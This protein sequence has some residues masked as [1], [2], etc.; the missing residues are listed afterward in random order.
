MGAIFSQFQPGDIVSGR[1]VPVTSGLFPEQQTFVSQSNLVCD[2]F[3]LTQSAATPSPSFGAS[4][5]DIRRTAYYTNVFP[6]TTTQANNDPYF[7][8]AYGNFFGNLGSGSFNLDTGSILVFPPKAVY[9]EYQN[10]LL[11]QGE[12]GLFQFLSGSSTNGQ[13]IT[14]YDIFVLDVSSYKMKDAMV[15]GMFQ[16]TLTGSN[17]SITL[18]DDS[19]FLAQQSSVY[20]L[21]T[22]S[23][24]SNTVLP[25]YQGIGLFYPNDGVVVF[26]AQVVNQL[27][28]LS[29]ISGTVG[30]VSTA[31]A[32]YNT[33]SIVGI[34][35]PGQTAIIPSTVNHYVFFWSIQNA[36]N[37]FLGIGKVENVPSQYY[38]VRVK[39]QEYN[40]SNN[41]TY[42]YDGQ[43]AGPGGTIFPA[44]T[45]FVQDFITNPTTYITSVGLYD[46]NNNLVAVG[47][48]SNP[49]VKTFTN[50]LLIQVSLAF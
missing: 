2:F 41:P 4:I 38:F 14:G 26:N 20:N 45:I 49:A 16:I 13:Y 33:S 9:T 19:P 24:N 28:G 22:G 46:N 35:I 37:S 17:G 48:L 6:D 7:A 40:Y 18:C 11:G 1:T 15:Q 39:N 25:P 31:I 47:K 44:G 21:I 42:V 27:I 43:T 34:S 36:S 32:N 30:P 50:E 5:Y 8:V 3:S 12:T 29:N 23:I 10:L